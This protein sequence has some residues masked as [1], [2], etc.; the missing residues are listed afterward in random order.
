M[1]AEERRGRVGGVGRG[2]RE[3][4]DCE[5]GNVLSEAGVVAGGDEWDLSGCLGGKSSHTR[6]STG[7]IWGDCT[8]E[9]L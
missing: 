4:R 6:A 2:W 5:D 8:E 7:R 9:R 1:Y 3:R